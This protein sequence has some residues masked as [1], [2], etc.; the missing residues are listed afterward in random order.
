MGFDLKKIT[1]KSLVKK[2]SINAAKRTI[3]EFS[4][5]YDAQIRAKAARSGMSDFLGLTPTNTWRLKMIDPPYS[6]FVGQ[7]KAE[8]LL[9]AVGAR[10]GDKGALNKQDTDKTWLG[11]EPGTL[12]FTTRIW[13]TDST[14][15]VRSTVET[16]REFTKRDPNLKRAPLFVFTSGI[17]LRFNVFVKSIGGIEYDSPRQDG[18]IRGATFK[19]TLVVVDEVPTEQTTMSLSSLC[20]TGL[21]I[22]SSAAVSAWGSVSKWINVPGGS[23]HVKGKQIIIKD[24]QTFEHI[25]QQEYGD[26]SFG[27]ILRRVHYDNP[28]NI[29]KN[30]LEVGDYI[31]L[32]ANEDIT[33]MKVT[34]QSIALKEAEVNL[35]NIRDHF[36]M[37]SEERKL[38][39][40]G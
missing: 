23:L 20:K 15:S 14:K 2:T 31:D 30:S 32:V 25:A 19:V 1:M 34:P 17:D 24:G 5:N 9:E 29:I 38:Y 36:V 8:N 35:Q 16:L 11:G 13:A 33:K 21:G 37:R 28:R 3:K 39:S 18:T 26:A 22:I 12:Q 40:G 4:A 7:H 27:D 6:S 10:I